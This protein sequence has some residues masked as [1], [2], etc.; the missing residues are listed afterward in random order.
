MKRTSSKK[1]FFYISC[2]L[3]LMFASFL[4]VAKAT[5]DF[6][7]LFSVDFCQS[8]YLFS[9][10]GLCAVAY[11][12]DT[13]TRKEAGLLMLFA[14]PFYTTCYFFI[15]ML[16]GGKNFPD[17]AVMILAMALV[18]VGAFY[19]YKKVM[20]KILTI[21]NGYQTISFIYMIVYLTIVL[22]ISFS[23]MA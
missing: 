6:E 16:V 10:M 15:C 19:T 11:V 8:Y 20:P 3:I 9:F 18:F 13:K 7:E 14:M 4:I 12:L 2:S 21:K 1:L 17:I 5:G 23:M 22:F